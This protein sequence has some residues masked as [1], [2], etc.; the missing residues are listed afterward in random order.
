[1]VIYLTIA[2]VRSLNRT[3][4]R[5]R[6]IFNNV[7]YVPEREDRILAFPVDGMLPGKRREPGEFPGVHRPL[8]HLDDR[9]V[10]PLGE[11]EL[12]G[13]VEESPGRIGADHPARERLLQGRPDVHERLR[14]RH[15]RLR[16]EEERHLVVGNEP[17]LPVSPVDLPD[18]LHPEAVELRGPERS[19]ARDADDPHAGPERGKVLPVGDGAVLEED[20]ID[21]PD[22]PGR[23]ACGL[24]YIA[25][26]CWRAVFG[27]E[28]L[29]CGRTV[30]KAFTLW[31]GAPKMTAMPGNEFLQWLLLRQAKEEGYRRM[32]NVG[33]N[34]EN[35]NLFKSKFNPSLTL[36]LEVSRQ[37]LFGRVARWAYS[38]IASK[39][40]MKR[41][42]L[43]YIE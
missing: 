8:R 24:R 11:V 4:R 16:V 40:P 34:N 21:E 22:D 36:F 19:H 2:A 25:P 33:A 27:V 42:V 18:A 20:A 32:E 10:G 14:E 37:D 1:M 9:I 41:K 3:V 26:F 13:G 35:L 15:A 5:S 38:A 43:S 28:D 7:P 17:P 39:G 23:G 6:P 30:T 31:M 12:V 29:P